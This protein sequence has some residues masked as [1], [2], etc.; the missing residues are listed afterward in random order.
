M[1]A[2]ETLLH[3]ASLSGMELV[4]AGW[5]D[6]IGEKYDLNIGLYKKYN[7]V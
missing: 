4:V 3:N 5:C 7:D 2:T 1:N 6:L